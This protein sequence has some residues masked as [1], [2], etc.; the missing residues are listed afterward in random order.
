MKFKEIFLI[1]RNSMNTPVNK[2]KKVNKTADR[3]A[4]MKEYMRKRN[5]T[6]IDEN[7]VNKTADMKAY[8]LQYNREY[9]IK[10]K[11]VLLPHGRPNEGKTSDIK[12]YMRN[13]MRDYMRKKRQKVNDEKLEMTITDISDKITEHLTI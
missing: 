3:N 6:I 10:K 7:K 13:Y 1:I 9:I 5:G 2:V 11:G 12:E 8:K 4:Y